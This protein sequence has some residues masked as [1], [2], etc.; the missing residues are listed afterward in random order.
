MNPSPTPDDVASRLN[1]ALAANGNSTFLHALGEIVHSQG[2]AEIASASGLS[3]ETLAE[4]LSPGGEPS[5]DTVRRVCR[6][7]GLRLVVQPLHA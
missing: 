1:A 7:L 2:Q 3:L 6:A 5:F 4:E